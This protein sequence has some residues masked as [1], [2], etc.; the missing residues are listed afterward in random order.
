MNGE[1]GTERPESGP[2]NVLTQDI[3]IR[4][5]MPLAVPL[6]VKF[7]RVVPRPISHHT[8]AYDYPDLSAS[9][10]V[11]RCKCGLERVFHNVRLYSPKTDM[12]EYACSRHKSDPVNHPM[13]SRAE[14]KPWTAPFN[15][16][17]WIPPKGKPGDPRDPVVSQF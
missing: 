12:V 5:E 7:H 13:L 2:V 15:P 4:R 14:L 10:P 3:Q 1:E 9:T 16:P 11:P 6:V 17:K 8:D